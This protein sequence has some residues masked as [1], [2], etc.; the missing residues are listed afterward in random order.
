MPARLLQVSDL[1]V[2]L[3]VEYLGEADDRGVLSRALKA[4]GM[5]LF[6]GHPGRIWRTP[7]QHVQVTWV[8]LE[9]EPATYAVGFTSNDITDLTI[10]GLGLLR[11]EEFRRRQDAIVDA[12]AGGSDLSSWKPPWTTGEEAS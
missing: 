3:T 4:V 1:R 6:P 10:P 11:Q 9:S 5:M 8:G 2:G 7:V 12:L